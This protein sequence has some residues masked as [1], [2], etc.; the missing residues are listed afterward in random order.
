MDTISQV[1]F[2]VYVALQIATFV[3]LWWLYRCT[4]LKPVLYNL[5]W[6]VADPLLLNIWAYLR[7]PPIHAEA[8]AFLFSIWGILAS[9]ANAVLL[10]WMLISMVRWA[11]PDS[12]LSWKSVASKPSA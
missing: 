3:F 5:L 8:A 6:R 1:S 12:P 2:V 4:G 11:R 10:V 7:Q 9:V